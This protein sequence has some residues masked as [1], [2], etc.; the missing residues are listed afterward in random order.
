MSARRQ[1]SSFSLKNDTLIHHALVRTTILCDWWASSLTFLWLFWV[2]G[3]GS[4]KYRTVGCLL[5][6][7]VGH[8]GRLKFACGTG[9]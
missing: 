3:F 7:N 5:H 9:M 1:L 2:Q 6:A 8:V 4:F